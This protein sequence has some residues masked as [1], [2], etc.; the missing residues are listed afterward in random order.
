MICMNLIRTPTLIL[1][2]K[3]VWMTSAV[4]IASKSYEL[5][6]SIFDTLRDIWNILTQST[7]LTKENVCIGLL[8]LFFNISILLMYI[9]MC[10]LII[11]MENWINRFPIQP[12]QD[13]SNS[14]SERNKIG[15]FIIQNPRSSSCFVILLS[16]VAILWVLWL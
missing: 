12:I 14:L 15:N 7:N 9:A 5:S 4:F 1:L 6:D 11:Y 3:A 16:L 10:I 2:T 8:F 13:T